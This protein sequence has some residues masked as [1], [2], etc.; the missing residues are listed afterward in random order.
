MIARG[1]YTSPH[2]N[3]FTFSDGSN[4]KPK[5]VRQTLYVILERLNLNPNLYNTHSFR[6][7]HSSD[8]LKHGKT[9]SEIKLAGR[10]RSSAVYHYLKF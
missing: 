3:L 1:G 8:M 2:E 6:S 5:N 4:V 10:W 9:L 7:G